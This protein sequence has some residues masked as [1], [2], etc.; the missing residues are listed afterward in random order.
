[1]PRSIWTPSGK[2][3]FDPPRV[4]QSGVVHVPATVTPTGEVVWSYGGL[5]GR[6]ELD[7]TAKSPTWFVPAP[8]IV[9]TE[10]IVG[11]SDWI[12]VGAET[13][14]V[15]LVST[16]GAMFSVSLD[17]SQNRNSADVTDSF[18]SANAPLWVTAEA[19]ASTDDPV[20]NAVSVILRYT[21]SL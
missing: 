15:V 9:L 21:T 4:K 16:G 8:G 3:V 17:T 5:V 2:P 10:L 6:V 18:V 7:G 13:I 11:I 12:A 14:E 19:T 20:A 1:M